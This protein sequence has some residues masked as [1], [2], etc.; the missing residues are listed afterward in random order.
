MGKRAYSI[1]AGIFL[2][3]ADNGSSTLG[4]VQSRLALDNGFPLDGTAAGL[5]ANLGDV[6]P[7][8]HFENV[9]AC[10]FEFVVLDR[11]REICVIRR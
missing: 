1:G 4:C 10:G 5:A 9:G 6:V 3:S 2:L 11:K 8:V 7:V